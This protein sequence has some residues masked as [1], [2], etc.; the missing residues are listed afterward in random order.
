MRVLSYAE[1]LPP[2]VTAQVLRA[3]SPS[4]SA[5][6]RSRG[7]RVLER[8]KR[9]SDRDRRRAEA[10]HAAAAAPEEPVP[11]PETSLVNTLARLDQDKPVEAQLS[12]RAAVLAYTD[13]E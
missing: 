4:G 11:H 1:L 5:D 2:P 7:R 13:S 9:A 10:Q 12:C 6:E 3:L 8:Q